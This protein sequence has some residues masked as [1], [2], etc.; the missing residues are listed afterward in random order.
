M[1]HLSNCLIL[2]TLLLL[3]QFSSQVDAFC[4]PGDTHC[5]GCWLCPGSD[6]RNCWN[7][8]LDEI[9]QCRITESLHKTVT[10]YCHGYA[11]LAKCWHAG[12]CCSEFSPL[13]AAAT[14]ICNLRTWSS[15]KLTKELVEEVVGKAYDVRNTI[16]HNDKGTD[17][18]KLKVTVKAFNTD[19][20]QSSHTDS[21]HSESSTSNEYENSTPESTYQKPAEHKPE[22]TESKREISPSVYHGQKNAHP[23][24]SQPQ[25]QQQSEPDHESEQD[26]QSKKQHSKSIHHQAKCSSKPKKCQSKTEQQYHDARSSRAHRNLGK[27]VEKSHQKRAHSRHALSKRFDEAAAAKACGLDF[28]GVPYPAEIPATVAHIFAEL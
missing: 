10:N 22:P 4:C 5:S 25:L 8:A 17:V 28:Q 26:T 19:F 13:L 2:S 6:L 7:G 21:Y 15:D 16:W 12:R 14:N 1:V 9:D 24:A 3:A 23:H 18:P 27:R 11:R 20:S